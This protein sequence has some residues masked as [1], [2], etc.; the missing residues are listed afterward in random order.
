MYVFEITGTVGIGS[1][2]AIW[3]MTLS[4][5]PKPK[6]PTDPLTLLF[7]WIMDNIF[8]AL[9]IVILLYLL[10]TYFIRK[11]DPPK[12]KNNASNKVKHKDSV[13]L[14]IIE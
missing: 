9:G 13:A 11:P 7:H 10:W 14:I 12:L 8:L 2:T 5:P 1:A 4:D 3:T 6:V